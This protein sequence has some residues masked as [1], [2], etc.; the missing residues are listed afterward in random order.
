MSPA[1]P[2]GA[3]ET[4]AIRTGIPPS[5][6]REHSE[7]L[8]LTS[9]FTFE[10]A[11]EARAMFAGEREGSI[12]TRY[13][14]PSVDAF[15]EKMCALEEAEGG[16]AVASG[17]SAI[18][19]TFA[20]LLGQGDEVFSARSVFGSTHQILTQILPRWGI[21]HVYGEITRPET[22]ADLVTE[23]TRL[24]YV[25]TPSNPTLDL[26][27]LDWLSGFCTERGITLV[28]D[29]IFATPVLQKPIRHGADL[30]IH[31]ATK[32]I[33]GQ[34]RGIG[35]VI[36]GR[37]EL[38][39]QVRFFARHTGP[40]LS[41]FNAWMFSKGLETLPLRIRQHSANAL[42]L[43]RFLEGRS[44]VEAVR[45]PHLP[46]HPQYALA[47]RQMALGGGIVTFIAEGG[48]ERGRRFLDALEMASLTA[49]LGDTRTIATHPAST[50]HSKLSE[51]ERQAVGI[52]P[53]TVRISVGL[54]HADD[55]LADV[56]QALDRSGGGV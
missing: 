39:E 27:D 40:A 19:T 24:C 52:E 12:Y 30:V 53:G 49:N 48:L 20:A 9:S 15:V 8:Y 50:T 3:D 21:G 51:A 31:S 13:S 35:G 25:E 45:Y 47:R 17:M 7:A 1:S 5:H 42:V 23:R 28:V 32:Y 14:N 6:H 26:I 55:I 29:N 37:E 16:V 56:A 36:V 2:T 18:F 33:D 54:E 41:P 44:D 4:R 34:G 11:E 10:N 22:W 38:V 46:S 43:A